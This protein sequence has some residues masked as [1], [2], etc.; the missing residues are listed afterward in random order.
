M[1]DDRLFKAVENSIKYAEENGYFITRSGPG[2]AVKEPAQVTGAAFLHHTSR[3]GDMQDH[4]HYA[5][6]NAMIKD[7]RKTLAGGRLEFKDIF[8][9]KM[10]LG[11]V[12]RAELAKLDQELGFEIERKGKFY[13]YL[14]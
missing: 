9:S 3:D 2:G 14:G 8:H 4:I 7:D 1:M 10:E 13:E 5:V 12:F 11:A 6:I